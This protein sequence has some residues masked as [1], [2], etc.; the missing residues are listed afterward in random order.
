MGTSSAVVLVTCPS[1]KVK[2]SVAKSP[3]VAEQCDVNDHSLDI[4]K[5]TTDITSNI[6]HAYDL[7]SKPVRNSNKTYIDSDLKS[8]FKQR[9]RA[10]KTWQFTRDP[11]DKT[12][13]N[14]L[15][16]KINRKVNALSQKQWEDKLTSLDPE[17]GSLWNMA[18][19]FRKKRSPISALTGPTG[20][21]YTDTQKAETLANALG[22]Q[23]QLNDIQNPDTDKQHMGLVDRFFI[24][25]NNF[26]DTPISTKPSEL[27]T[28]IKK[29]K[30]KKAP[31][32]D[33]IT[34][35]MVLN[36]PISVI[37]QLT[38]LINKILH[39]GQFPQAWKTATVI[40]IL[41][42][43]KDPTLATS[44]RPISLLPVLSKLAERIILNRLNDHLQNNDILIPQQH[45]F[46]ANLSTSHQL[47]RV[48]EYVKTGFAENKSTGAVFLD[49][50]KAFDRV[51]HYGLLYKLIHSLPI[52]AEKLTPLLLAV[53]PKKVSFIH[54]AHPEWLHPDWPRPNYSIDFKTPGFSRSSQKP[55]TGVPA[56][57][58]ARVRH[59]LIP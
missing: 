5:L 31:G 17:D 12:I 2:R 25:D 50:Q 1:F 28:Y 8:L 48:V 54:P 23:F 14:R 56:R 32:R 41:K 38:N 21:A 29:M 20:I 57:R 16:N 19:G 11:N 39:S 18:K 24:N 45:G 22:D 40:P 33:K 46:R 34:N 42:P 43:G 49:I 47:L 6:L 53:L 15:Q 3:R 26:D 44:H 37:F 36:F 51:W 27:L 35:K 55:L 13:L 9:N 58:I 30:I 4:E 52:G 7:S 59:I 10:R